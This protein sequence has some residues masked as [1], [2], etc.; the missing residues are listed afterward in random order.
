[1]QDLLRAESAKVARLLQDENCFV[2][3]CG[4]KGMEAGVIDA[5]RDA[6]RAHGLDW[7]QVKPALLEKSRLHIETY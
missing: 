3:L 6:C 4:L 5:F 2:Y 1:V 7:D